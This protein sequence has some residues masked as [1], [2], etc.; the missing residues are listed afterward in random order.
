MCIIERERAVRNNR[1][2][3]GSKAI[4]NRALRAEKAQASPRQD[5]NFPQGREQGMRGKFGEGKKNAPS[6]PKRRKLPL[7]RH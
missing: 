2:V 3:S 6:G 4:S 5:Q 1:R 7:S